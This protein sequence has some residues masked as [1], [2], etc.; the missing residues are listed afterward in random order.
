MI[1]GIPKSADSVHY[2]VV[3]KVATSGSVNAQDV[4]FDTLRL[5]LQRLLSERFGLKAR[6]QDRPVS[7]YTM[8][9]GPQTKLQKAD[10]QNR[11]NCK[12]GGSAKNPMLN[13]LITCQNMSMTQ[14][15]EAL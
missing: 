11:T 2:D 12:S 1:A 8:T 6:M 5:M 14:F 7:A 4:D 3:A 9:A 13:R 15:A 10:P